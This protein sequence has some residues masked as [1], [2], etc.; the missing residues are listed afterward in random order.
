MMA[1]GL[2]LSLMMFVY[3]I[4]MMRRFYIVLIKWKFPGIKFGKVLKYKVA[5]MIPMLME[6]FILLTFREI[7]S[8]VT[9]M[10]GIVTI[11]FIIAAFS[12]SI[13]KNITREV[14]IA[15]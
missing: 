2:I 8:G 5:V 10:I 6:L 11:C 7:S 13:I 4:L 15:H 9:G 3:G 12:H 14:K 1:Q